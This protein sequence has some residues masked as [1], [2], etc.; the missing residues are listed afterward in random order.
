MHPLQPSVGLVV[1][2]SIAELPELDDRIC[3]AGLLAVSK[4]VRG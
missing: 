4:E 3:R 1:H 2:G